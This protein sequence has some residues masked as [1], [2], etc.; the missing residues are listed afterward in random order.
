MSHRA[1]SFLLTIWSL[2]ALSCKSPTESHPEPDYYDMNRYVGTWQLLYARD[3][4][5]DSIESMQRLVLRADS[6]YTSTFALCCEHPRDTTHLNDPD[7]GRWK[8]RVGSDSY[9]Q[10]D[11]IAGI[12]FLSNDGFPRVLFYRVW[13]SREEGTFHFSSGPETYSWYLIQ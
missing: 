3:H 12:E 11:P 10:P 13:G 5:A 4:V 9:P 8:T 2:F 7:Y 1:S 6:S